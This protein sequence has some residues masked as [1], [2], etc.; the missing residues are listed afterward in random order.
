MTRKKS[1][2]KVVPFE[3]LLLNE[4]SFLGARAKDKAVASRIE[5][6]DLS[7]MLKV[8]R[9]ATTYYFRTEEKRQLFLKN[10]PWQQLT[11]K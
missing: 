6:P 1:N 3:E 5:S 9:G 11:T 8:H 2:Q 10:N 4:Q 7:K